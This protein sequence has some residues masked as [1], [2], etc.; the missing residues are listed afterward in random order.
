MRKQ[1]TTE[2]Y[3]MLIGKLD[4]LAHKKKRKYSSDLLLRILRETKLSNEQKAV[5]SREIAYKMGT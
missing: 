3:G 4:I 2:Y 5:F 1:T